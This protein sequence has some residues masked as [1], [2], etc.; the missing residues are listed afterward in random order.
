MTLFSL[1]WLKYSRCILGA[2]VIDWICRNPPNF[3]RMFSPDQKCF[4][5]ILCQ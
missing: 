4:D 2:Q 3:C 1:A 5:D